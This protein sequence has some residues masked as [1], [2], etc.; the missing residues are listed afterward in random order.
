MEWGKDLAAEHERYLAEEVIKKPIIVY[1]YPK[2]IK[3]FYMRLNEDGKTV[4][5]MDI[6][7]PQIGELIGGSQREERFDLLY[8]RMKELNMLKSSNSPSSTN[9]EANQPEE[10]LNEDVNNSDLYWYLNLRQYGTVKHAGFG[11]GFERLVMFITG[12]ENIRDVT[13]FPRW[14]GNAQF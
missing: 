10:T 2:D 6:L 9:S 12:V 7:F 14:M 4:A 5:A 8:H 13:P 1:N 11:V 3:A